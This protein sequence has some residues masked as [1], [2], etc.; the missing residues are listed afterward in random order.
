MLLRKL[1]FI[2]AQVYLIKYKIIMRQYNKMK[3]SILLFS[4]SVIILSC[5]TT[6]NT[7]S[8]TKAPYIIPDSI[9]KNLK[10]DTVVNTQLINTNTFTGKVTFNDE[11]N[12]KDTK[13][14]SEIKEGGHGDFKAEINVKC[15]KDLSGSKV[16]FGFNKYFPNVKKIDAQGLSNSNQTAVK[17]TKKEDFLQL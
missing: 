2:L 9:L 7:A 15:K 11:N 13:S 14:K 4:L 17:V 1:T 16:T 6:E 3:F 8:N 12:V 10:I 5:G